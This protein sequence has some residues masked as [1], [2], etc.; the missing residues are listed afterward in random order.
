MNTSISAN[1]TAVAGGA[2]ISLQAQRPS[3][4]QRWISFGE[5]L[6]GS[7]IV[8]G[9]NVYH[10][11]PNEV[12]ILVVL[13]LISFRLRDGWS[14]LG[15]RWP[16]SWRRTVLI[17]L[18]AATLRILFGVLLIEPVTAHFWP[19]AV[20]PSGMNHIAGHWIHA[21]RWFLLVW[22]FAAFGEEIGYRGYL[23]NRGADAGSQS[24][25]AYWVAVVVVSVLFGYGHYYK[26]PA[27]IVDSGMAGL[28]LGAAYVLS[29]RNLWVCVLAHGFIDTIGLIAVFFGW[30]S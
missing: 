25:S 29:G 5:F 8:I 22:T 11:V 23:I 15:L 6:V 17:A 26:G 10:V 3:A 18:A 30:S 19:P 21:L 27:G 12:P 1:T 20:A 13:A 16:V 2:A 24:K 9:H 4:G 28:V 14:A 7:A